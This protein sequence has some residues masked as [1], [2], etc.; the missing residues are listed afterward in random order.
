MFDACNAFVQCICYLTNYIAFLHTV[1]HTV[2]AFS[3]SVHV[4]RII[5]INSCRSHSLIGFDNKSKFTLSLYQVKRKDGAHGIGVQN[6]TSNCNVA[7]LN[8]FFFS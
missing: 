1:L 6:V 2:D 3:C 5:T 4:N 7:T 8:Y